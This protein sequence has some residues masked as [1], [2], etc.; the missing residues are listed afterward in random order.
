MTA[1]ASYNNFPTLVLRE[2]E[3]G[4]VSGVL[5]RNPHCRDYRVSFANNFVEPHE[6][7]DLIGELNDLLANERYMGLY[8]DCDI[9]AISLD[10]AIAQTP[11]TETGQK[12]VLVYRKFEWLSGIWNN[13]QKPN[14]FPLKLSSVAD[15]HGLR[16]SRAKRNTRVGLDVAKAKQTI[17]GDY[18]VLCSALRQLPKIDAAEI[19]DYE[20]IPAIKMLCNWWNTHAPESMRPA[21]LFRVYI[22]N[23]NR[24]T[25]IAGDSEEPAL[26]AEVLAEIPAYAI[27]TRDGLPTVALNFYRGR[28][29]N[30]TH[31]GATHV[32]YANGEFGTDIGMDIAEVDEAFYA[33]RGLRAIHID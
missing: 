25:F 4:S 13:P 21:A 12:D 28:S 23:Q 1:K 5:M 27:F 30:E 19:G 11:E 24:R 26:M 22:W 10:D 18:D 7:D 6:V 14:A 29:Y 8:K 16:V 20:A 3:D 15:F 17:P 2:D 33:L 32:F 9:S 31:E